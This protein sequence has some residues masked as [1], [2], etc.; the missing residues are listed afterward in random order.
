M[1]K[2][3]SFRFFFVSLQRRFRT[4]EAPLESDGHVG[5]KGFL[6]GRQT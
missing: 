4:T 2:I 3:V 5:G 1:K 6:Q